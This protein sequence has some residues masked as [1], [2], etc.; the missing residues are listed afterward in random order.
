MAARVTVDDVKLILDVDTSITDPM[1]TVFISAATILVDKVEDDGGITD[2]VQ[3]KEI[4]RWLAA[5][6]VAIRDVRSA[7]EKAGPVG[8]SFQYKVDLNLNQTQYGQQALILDTSGVLAGLQAQASGGG[9]TEAEFVAM[10]P[11]SDDDIASGV[12]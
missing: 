5:H 6:F 3:L 9:A 4:E 2:E 1:V 10:G 12:F 11:V 8:Q 7:S